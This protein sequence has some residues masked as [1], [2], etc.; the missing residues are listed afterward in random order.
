MTGVEFLKQMNDID[1]DLLK[2]A[3]KSPR[4]HIPVRFGW[5][6]AFAAGICLL[7]GAGFM[8]SRTIYSREN[9]TG[10]LVA[11][12]LNDR[13]YEPFDRDDYI[14]YGLISE[15]INARAVVQTPAIT[16]EDLGN[17]M[18]TVD[19]LVNGKKTSCRVYYTR[20]MPDDDSIC[21]VEVEHG[22]YGLYI[23]KEPNQ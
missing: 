21:I 15:D 7:F 5:G 19:V 23:A 8:V 11:F 14:E 12:S 6:A 22:E 20:L 9:H 3:E 1:E 16:G 18:G 10:C 13:S 2:E 4:R 17:L